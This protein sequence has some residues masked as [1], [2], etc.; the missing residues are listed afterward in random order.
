MT[1]SYE[2]HVF[3]IFIRWRRRI[4]WFIHLNV[5]WMEQKAMAHS[6]AKQFRQPFSANTIVSHLLHQNMA[7]FPLTCVF[8]N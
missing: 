6:N 1:S 8:Y 4:I 7:I 5:L 3:S 2:C